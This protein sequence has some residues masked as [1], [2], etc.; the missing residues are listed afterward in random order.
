MAWPSIQQSIIGIISHR[1]SNTSPQNPC[2]PSTLPNPNIL[3]LL[4][5]LPAPSH[6]TSRRTNTLT[7]RPTRITLPPR[8]QRP[9]Q[10]PNASLQRL[11]LPLH[12]IQLMS[13]I[14]R[15]LIP[16][17][18]LHTRHRVRTVSVSV[19]VGVAETSEIARR[20]L[21]MLWQC[22]PLRVEVRKVIRLLPAALR[23]GQWCGTAGAAAA[24]ARR[25]VLAGQGRGL[26]DAGGGLGACDAGDGAGGA[27]GEAAG[28]CAGGGAVVA[29]LGGRGVG[30]AGEE[31][32]CGVV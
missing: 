4:L 3:V 17:R 13:M 23:R 27:G 11:I 2:T 14:R 8:P 6:P 19:P 32:V 10:I 9:L 21:A 16:P 22:W 26:R 7:P 25:A 5:P 29:A 30:G 18:R 15:L 1:P 24:R 12:H 20:G 31:M 28:G